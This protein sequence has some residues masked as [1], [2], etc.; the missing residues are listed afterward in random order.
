MSV[1]LIPQDISCVPSE[2]TQREINIIFTL[3]DQTS[4][5]FIQRVF[6]TY[7]VLTLVN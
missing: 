5:D 7:P 1:T 4:L 2:T 6:I 3:R